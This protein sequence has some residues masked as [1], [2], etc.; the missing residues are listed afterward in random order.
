[1]NSRVKNYIIVFILVGSFVASLYNIKNVN[2][3]KK[4][5]EVSNKKYKDIGR[6]ILP[7]LTMITFFVACYFISLIISEGEAVGK[8]KYA[9]IIFM[10]VIGLILTIMNFT[11]LAKN[12]L[13]T[14]IKGKK[15]SIIGLFMALGV[16]AIVFGFLDNFGMKLGTEALDDNFLQMFLSP[17]SQDER[18]LDHSDNIKDNLKTINDWVSSDW[19]KLVNH[20]LRFKDD[21]AKI[22]KFKDLSRAINKFNCDKLIIPK[23]ILKDRNLTN[24]FVDNLRSKYDIIDGSKAM[25]GNTFS[26][27]IG[28]ILGAA[29]INL[30]TYMTTYDASITGDDDIDN[31]FFVRNLNYYAPFMEALF[32]ALGCLVPVFL[33]IAMNRNSNSKNNFYAWL[34]VAIVGILIIIM[35]YF[36]SSGVKEMNFDDKKRSIK[37]SLESIRERVNLNKNNGQEEERLNDYVENFI[38]NL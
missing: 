29:L 36:S 24:D 17:F 8:D 26:D 37:K 21:I 30:F 31:N 7:T 12:K 25:L 5:D 33:N 22:D 34:V 15:F 35:M 10:F 3:Q 38:N 11:V 16:S 20:V 2:E 19:R 6:F 32:I 28:A 14:Y 27:F 9:G 18:F 4:K 1:M 13:D 23:N